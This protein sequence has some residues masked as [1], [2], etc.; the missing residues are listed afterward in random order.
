MKGSCGHQLVGKQ[1]ARRS[2]RSRTVSQ[3]RKDRP[4]IHRRNAHRQ[5]SGHGVFHLP[6]GGIRCWVEARGGAALPPSTLKGELT[7]HGGLL[8]FWASHPD[9]RSPETTLSELQRNGFLEPTVRRG[10]SFLSSQQVYRLRVAVRLARKDKIDLQDALKR[11]KARWLAQTT[12]FE[13]SEHHR[14]VA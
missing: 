6:R 11:V 14:G 1:G 8:Q 4:E 5:E 12:A 9:L 7:H 3:S 10:R 2:L 13:G